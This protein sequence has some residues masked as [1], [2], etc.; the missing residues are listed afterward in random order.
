M[1]K[2][3][4]TTLRIFRLFISAIVLLFIVRADTARA[5][6]PVGSANFSPAIPQYQISA[7]SM[8]FPVY[9]VVPAADS[10][11]FGLSKTQVDRGVGRAVDL[12]NRYAMA[13]VRFKYQG[14]IS[15][16]PN[17]AGSAVYIVRNNCAATQPPIDQ[18]SGDAACV[19]PAPTV[20]GS[21]NVVR[22]YMRI[23]YNAGVCYDDWTFYPDQTTCV[24][25][26]CDDD[27][28]GSFVH[29]LIHVTGF[30][31]SGTSG[32]CTG[33]SG[34]VG[35]MNSP[36]TRYT[37]RRY[38]SR[39]DIDGLVALYGRPSGNLVDY[40]YSAN[41]GTTWTDGALF[42]SSAA[43]GPVAQV[44]KA[45]E[46]ETETWVSYLSSASWVPRVRRQ[47]YN[48]TASAISLSANSWQ[49]TSI[50]RGDGTIA[51]ARFV[52]ETANN[53]SRSLQFA[54]S[55]DAGASWSYVYAENDDS[56]TIQTRRHGLG[57]AF[58]PKTARFV[59]AY[60]GDDNLPD[61]GNGDACDEVVDGVLCDEIRIVSVETDGTD[62]GHTNLGIRSVVAPFVACG[63]TVSTHNC[64]V[65]WVS[66]TGNSCLH[67]GYGHLNADGTFDLY[68]DQSQGCYYSS[69]PVGVAYDREE[70]G[71][72]WRFSYGIEHAYQDR[73]YIARKTSS[74]VSALNA[75]TYFTVA[76]GFRV[77]GDIALLEDPS[78]T[79]VMLRTVYV[80][81]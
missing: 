20:D 5:N 66:E 1:K 45:T 72:P 43:Y 46:G 28:I 79:E 70:P 30:A 9:L 80:R 47:L 68:N 11:I 34:S 19:S 14:I 52:D 8:P 42:G 12:V 44:A 23:S 78:S 73:V 51:V 17:P 48:S 37:D 3:P 62:Q 38:L 54:M 10:T 69:G 40:H 32:N 15:A 29:E 61:T 81:R 67:W 35:S 33:D 36:G 39:D 58:D 65:T 50:A 60:Q 2:M 26:D 6:C 55:D 77:L 18:C 27:L 57:L 74:Y 75:P 76:N 49:P 63:D 53:N 16:V 25:G 64:I 24:S 56:N 7:A 31:H 13:N 71:T 21:G 4:R 59:A 22:A 41:G